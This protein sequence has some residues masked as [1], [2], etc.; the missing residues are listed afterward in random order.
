MSQVKTISTRKVELKNYGF[1]T[2]NRINE[3]EV[4]MS[5]KGRDFFVDLNELRSA[6]EQDDE[7]LAAVY[8]AVLAIAL[9]QSP[10]KNVYVSLQPCDGGLYQIE[11][12][13]QY[14]RALQVPGIAAWQPGH[15]HE[16][17]SLYAD[18]RENCRDRKNFSF[19]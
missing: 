14:G 4:Y 10:N 8:G 19:S 13:N 11:A 16:I 17:K 7:E 6:A 18:L 9:A 15:L 2:I 5:R 1:G 3:H 12:K